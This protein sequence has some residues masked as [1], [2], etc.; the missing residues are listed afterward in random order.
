MPIAI[1]CTG[2]KQRLRVPDKA[3]GR[4]VK[5]PKCQTV[6][7][8]PKLQEPREAN[9]AE[10][11]VQK[12]PTAAEATADTNTPAEP[13]QSAAPQAAARD[14][15]DVDAKKALPQQPAAKDQDAPKDKAE[16]SQPL[17][18]EK[19]RPAQPTGPTE[20]R[21]LEQATSAKRDKVRTEVPET[22][23]DRWYLKTEDGED[24]GPVSKTELDEWMQEGRITADCHVLRDGDEQWQWASDVY[25]ELESDDETVTPAGP[26]PLRTAA[27]PMATGVPESI[28]NVAD[29]STA[30]PEAFQFAAADTS[31]TLRARGRRRVRKAVK[32]D[33]ATTSATAVRTPHSSQGTSPKSKLT[34]GLLGIFLGGYGVHRFYLGYTGMGL[35]MLFTCG[36]CGIWALIDAIMVLLGKVPDA[37]GRPLRD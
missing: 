23:P 5:C 3:A 8:I 29:S 19:R 18:E 27:A 1:R 11:P 20:A 13:Q 14:E 17:D 9:T 4:R 35:L 33:L 16:D 12:Q 2:C 15:K 25:P 31:P 26:P 36:G 24:Y 28:P 21:R 7:R 32:K 37:Q 10:R 22:Q 30:S 6:L 34:A